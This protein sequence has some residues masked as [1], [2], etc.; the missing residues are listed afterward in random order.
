MKLAHLARERCRA[1]QE[2]GFYGIEPHSRFGDK[3]LGIGVNLSP[4]RECG[5][6]WVNFVAVNYRRYGKHWGFLLTE[7][8]NHCIATD[9]PLQLRTCPISLDPLHD[10][11]DN[12][13]YR[14]TRKDT[15]PSSFRRQTRR[16][17]FFCAL[18]VCRE[19]Q[20]EKS[21][22]G[23]VLPYVLHSPM[24]LSPQAFSKSVCWVS[25]RIRW[26]ISHTP[27]ATFGT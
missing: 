22:E 10:F 25:Y 7:H 24:G 11:S 5:S 26:C 16:S 17:A 4:E 23:C 6:K 15:T 14:T 8:L 9:Q 13:L 12:T 1:P 19:D 3:L 27:W 18:S 20:A 2:T 21:S